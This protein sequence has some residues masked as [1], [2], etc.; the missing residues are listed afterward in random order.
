MNRLQSVQNAG[1]SLVTGTRRSDHITPVLRQ[2]HWLPVRQNVDFKVATL[3]HRSLSGISSSYLQY[4]DRRLFADVRERRLYV[5][6]TT[7]RT[8]IV[9]CDMDT[10]DDSGFAVA[11]PGLWNW[12][13]SQVKEAD[14]SCNR[15]RRSLKTFLF[16]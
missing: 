8:C 2:L 7:C 6:S 13:P 14:L 9:S 15:F 10:F 11:G 4:N 1:A 5:R 12:L 16:G 3:V